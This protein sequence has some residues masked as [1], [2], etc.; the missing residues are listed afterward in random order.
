MPSYAGLACR[1]FSYS[2]E[3]PGGEASLSLDLDWAAECG[4]EVVSDE[5]VCG[6]RDLY[7]V[8][9]SVGLH[10]AGCVDSVAPDV[11]LEFAGSNY[12]RDRRS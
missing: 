12:A 10:S 7:S 4:F 6:F 1:L 11:V 2:V 5:L 9:F 3:I 8:G